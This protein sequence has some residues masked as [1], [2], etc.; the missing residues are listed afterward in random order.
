[1]ALC[2]PLNECPIC[3]KPI[4][5]NTEVIGFPDLVP[6]FSQFDGDFYDSCAHQACLDS[7]PRRDEFV[8]YF[9]KL[10]AESSLSKSWQLHVLANGR[11]VYER[12]LK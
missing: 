11:V 7:W 6:M 12:S 3:H 5:E 8:A 10:V 1:M 4:G 2:T 9:N